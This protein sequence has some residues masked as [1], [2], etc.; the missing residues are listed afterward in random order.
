MIVNDNARDNTLLNQALELVDTTVREFNQNTQEEQVKYWQVAEEFINEKTTQ[1]TLASLLENDICQLSDFPPKMTD[2]I[3]KVTD[4]L[5]GAFDYQITIQPPDNPIEEFSNENIITQYESD[6]LS[7]CILNPEMDTLHVF[8][9]PPRS[10]NVPSP[11]S[12]NFYPSNSPSNY[13][14]SPET[15]SPMYNSDYE[16]YQ[17]IFSE[18]PSVIDSIED[19]D[20]DKKPRERIP[21]TSMTMK[22]YK[23]MQKEIANEFSKMECC[24]ANRK[25]CKEIFQGHLNKLKVEHRKMLC[26]KV[27]SLDM[28][29]AYG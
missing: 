23:D 16:R 26:H 21:S 3:P 2:D 13:T 20:T 29:K 1:D 17:D 6:I 7:E 12:D 5:I 28:T 22:Q 25:S 24:L 14:L 11:M 10:E 9:T 4:N 18:Y 27:A 15:S 19:Q 8:P